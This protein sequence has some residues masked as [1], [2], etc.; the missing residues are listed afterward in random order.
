[1]IVNYTG[2][3]SIY[4]ADAEAALRSS[5]AADKHLVQVDADHFGLPLAAAPDR[6]GRSAAAAH[7]N[8]WLRDRFDA[9]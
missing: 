5:A 1:L 2:D 3:P 4:P 7:I 9:R 8:A 6:D